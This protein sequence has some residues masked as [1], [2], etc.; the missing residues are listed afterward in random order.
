MIHR[1]VEPREHL[2]IRSY[3]EPAPLEIKAPSVLPQPPVWVKSTMLKN[4][5]HDIAG[6]GL[7]WCA[8]NGN[9][10]KGWTFY[11]T[12]GACTP[13]KRSFE[14]GLNLIENHWALRAVLDASRESSNGGINA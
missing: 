5:T 4:V 13:M 11:C 10:A 12:C 7:A 14:D 2:Q 8:W 9:R 1:F 6:H 3:Y